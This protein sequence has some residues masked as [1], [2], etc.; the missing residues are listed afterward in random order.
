MA[1]KMVIAALV[2]RSQTYF[3]NKKYTLKLNYIILIFNWV[4]CL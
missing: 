2:A 3:R 1:V 4:I